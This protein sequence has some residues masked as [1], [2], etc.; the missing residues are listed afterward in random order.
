[1]NPQTWTSLGL[2]VSVVAV[3]VVLTLWNESA[4]RL[5]REKD[6]VDPEE[7]AYLLRRYRRRTQTNILLGIVGIA[8]AGGSLI[9]DRL[10]LLVYWGSV[11]LVAAWVLILGFMD[12]LDTRMHYQGLK[13]HCEQRQELLRREVDEYFQAKE[14]T[15][16]E[17]N[18]A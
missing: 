5:L 17:S 3:S 2:S 7:F 10:T 6:R 4:G 12:A 16:Q 9:S 8:I 13:D 11:F 1:M 15:T 18:D 14:Q